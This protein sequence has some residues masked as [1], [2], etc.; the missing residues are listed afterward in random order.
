MWWFWPAPARTT[1]NGL[2]FLREAIAL[3][4]LPK[5]IGVTGYSG[6]DDGAMAKKLL[7]VYGAQY[8]LMKPFEPQALVKLVKTALR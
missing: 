7:E 3:E 2:D 4:P 5:V 6:S 1:D 8:I